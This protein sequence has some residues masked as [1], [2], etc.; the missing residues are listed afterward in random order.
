MHWFSCAWAIQ[1]QLSFAPDR[2]GIHASFPLFEEE[3]EG[4]VERYGLDHE[5]TYSSAS[6]LVMLLRKAGQKGKAKQL[7]TKHARRVA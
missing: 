2:A 3:L 4:C 1:A 6:N 7:A 5:E